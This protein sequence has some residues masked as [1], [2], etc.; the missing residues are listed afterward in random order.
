MSHI[1][2]PSRR[3]WTRQPRNIQG[4]A[5]R[6]VQKS[7]RAF[8][9]PSLGPVDILNGTG[10]IPNNGPS[11]KGFQGC[12]SIV[13]TAGSSSY[14]GFRAPENVSGSRSSKLYDVSAPPLTLISISTANFNSGY[15]LMRGNGSGQPA[16][17]AGAWYG[18]FK[19]GTGY[20]RTTSGGIQLAPQTSNFDT[21]VQLAV[22][23]LSIGPSATNLWCGPIGSG[24]LHAASAATPGGNFYYEYGDAYRCLSIGAN[25]SGFATNTVGAGMFLSEF[26]QDDAAALIANP[27]GLFKARRRISYF[28][29]GAGAGST[30]NGSA[31]GAA[32]AAGAA[33]LAAQVALSA[34]GVS[35]ATGGAAGAISV[36]LSAT[37]VEV[38][39]GAAA[40]TAT[41]TLSAAALA[42]SAGAAG[43]SSAVLLAGAAA[44][45][46][47]G[48]GQLAVLLAAQAAGVEQS[49]GS[50]TATGGALGSIAAAGQE[51]SGGQ[52]VLQV[53]INLQAAGTETSSGAALATAS[54]AGQLAAQGI[55]ATGGTAFPTVRIN[56][57]AA[58]QAT[59]AGTASGQAIPGNSI[60]GFG[61]AESAGHAALSVTVL[62]TAAG[63]VQ[64]MGAGALA[65]EI[66]LAAFGIAQTGGA[67]GLA[68]I[69][70]YV[71][72][73]P[74]NLVASVRRL[75][76][77]QI[78][79][80]RP[81]L[82][83]HGVSR[84]RH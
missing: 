63:F 71:P 17:A 7:P 3:V 24:I 62:V 67:A 57:A 79:A 16:F 40:A 15:A 76:S 39:S 48:N 28:D 68:V 82:L 14:V 44:A 34:V 12:A 66:P 13:S 30:L 55:G 74:L 69:P 19:G 50:A 41:I 25:Y 35:S 20:V 65:I 6:W 52:A 37:G 84:V 38:S 5:D 4:L 64:A 26:S 22:T 9:L 23:V 1:I 11:I 32:V 10:F 31:T 53:S 47:A 72:V 80:H 45:Q 51:Q 70:D 42:E 33:A 60:T 59:T 36:P 46:S 27:W 73:A 8:F 77:L 75:A 29:L 49:G 43:L 2:V 61:H 58:G 18:S 81:C 21:S 54:T 56:T 83:R 78:A